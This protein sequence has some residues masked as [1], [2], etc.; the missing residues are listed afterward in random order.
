MNR[1]GVAG[2]LI[3]MAGVGV[4]V[5]AFLPLVE[6][7]VGAA[8]YADFLRRVNF[9]VPAQYWLWPLITVLA[10][11]VP[12]GITG[13]LLL[14]NRMPRIGLGLVLGVSAWVVVPALEALLRPEGAFEFAQGSG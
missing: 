14:V 10:Q 4:A 12:L 7:D 2:F 3:L 13:I 8:A 9:R 1:R 5:A 11:S 6:S